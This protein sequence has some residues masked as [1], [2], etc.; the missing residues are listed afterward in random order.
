MDPSIQSLSLAACILY[1]T[2]LTSLAINPPSPPQSSN[3]KDR[4]GVPVHGAYQ[5]RYSLILIFIY[6]T[7][8]ILFLNHRPRI[9][10]NPEL[11]NK[12][13]FFVELADNI[14]HLGSVPFSTNP[15]LDFCAPGKRFHLPSYETEKGRHH[16]HL[17]IC[18]ASRVRF[19]LPPALCSQLLSW[20]TWCSGL[21]V[22]YVVCQQQY[23]A[24][25]IRNALGRRTNCHGYSKD[26]R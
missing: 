22:T 23:S 5:I 26:R 13:L 21:L 7:I 1:C 20:W 14:L 12:T 4:L 8:L 6:R 3:I 2:Y 18:A 9:Y 17:S 15:S 24:C 16:W 11:L 10:R 25:I 19:V